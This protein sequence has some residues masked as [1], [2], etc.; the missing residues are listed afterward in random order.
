[1]NTQIP[2]P[3]N[4][5]STPFSID[6]NIAKMK[7]TLLK[8]IQRSAYVYR[9]DCGGCNGCESRFL[10]L[11]RQLLMRNVLVLK[12]SLH[13]V[14]QTF[15]C[16]PVPLLVRCVHLLCVLTKPRRILKSVF[17]TVL[18]VAVAASSMIC[19]VFGAVVIK[20]YQLMCTSLAVLQL[21][22]RPFMDSQSTWFA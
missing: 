19:I 10:V 7:Q 4:G 21:Q 17:L 20:L 16:L 9:V 1:M 5:I 11:L 13:L 3:V 14:M 18:A 15:Y 2:M 22:Q 12:W 8:D 6:E